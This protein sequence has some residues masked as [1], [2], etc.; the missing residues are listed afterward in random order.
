MITPTVTELVRN[1]NPVGER[2]ELRRYV[3]RGGERF[4]YGQ[5]VD[6]AVRFLPRKPVVL[7]PP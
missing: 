2:V 7:A 1:G 5:R 4:L 6:G 3:L